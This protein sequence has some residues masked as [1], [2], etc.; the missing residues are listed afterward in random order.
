MLLAKLD[1]AMTTILLD[2][3]PEAD[4]EV[5]TRADGIEFM[6]VVIPKRYREWHWVGNKWELL[7]DNPTSV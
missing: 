2:E 1:E 6:K 7:Y 5:G 4:V 3:P